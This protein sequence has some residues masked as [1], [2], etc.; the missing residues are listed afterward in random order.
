VY[1]RQSASCSIEFF[2]RSPL[3]GSR[4]SEGAASSTADTPVQPQTLGLHAMR[5]V[6]CLC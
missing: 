6:I 1:K 5:S 2:D 3:S 4:P